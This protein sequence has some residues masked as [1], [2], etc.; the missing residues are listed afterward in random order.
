[1]TDD[2]LLDRAALEREARRMCQTARL[3]DGELICRVLGKYIMYVDPQ[4]RGIT[5]H[6]ALNGFWESW[7]TVALA[8]LIQPGWRCIDIGA[9]VGY[10]TLLMA[11]RAGTAGRVMALE[12]NPAMARHL[13]L[14]V[15]VNGFRDRVDMRGVAAADRDDGEARLTVDPA[16]PGLAT[17]CAGSGRE[18]Q[19]IAA[20]TATVDRLVA[21]WPCVDLV[22]IDA[23]GAEPAIWRGMQRTLA[24]NA[25]IAVVLE[26]SPSLYD[27][28][29][30]FLRE[31]RAG[32]F[33]PRQVAPDGT[34]APLAPEALAEAAAS[35][36]STMLFLSR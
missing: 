35:G 19:V 11:D 6:L 34:I 7:V 9:N 29:A 3:G 24:R 4:D 1:V 36:G 23:E 8:R 15:C 22:K 20:R 32:G 16:D 26:F 31:M 21:A 33:H 10:F 12:P 13:E 30:G 5:P 27:D 14:N 17:I 18:G 28:A 25:R 2:D